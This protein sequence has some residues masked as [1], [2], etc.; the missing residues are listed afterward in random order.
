MSMNSIF[1][2][3]RQA[4]HDIPGCLIASV[5]DGQSGMSLAAVCAEDTSLADSADAYHADL[6][7]LVYNAM[8]AL[9]RPMLPD[10]IVLIAE[11]AI[12]ISTPFPGS[13]YFWHVVTRI[14]TTVGFTQAIMR[15]Y[16]DR[17]LASMR[18]VLS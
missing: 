4:A 8:D 2:V 7:R 1:E 16:Q 11:Q 10:G 17:V 12:F 15:K 5:V 3:L 9:D 13:P 18:E 6:Y 14:D